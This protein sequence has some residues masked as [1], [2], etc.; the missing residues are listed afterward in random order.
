MEIL[1]LIQT[2]GGIAGGIGI[3]AFTKS[4]RLKERAEAEKKVQE[5]HRMMIDNYEERIKDLH[6]T[7]NLMNESE[8]HYI[9]RISAQNHA[10]DSKTEQI[11]NLTQ[12]VW[13]SEQEV[14]RV[15]ELLNAANQR[16]IE[17][18][19]ERDNYRNWHCRKGDCPHREP[20]NPSLLHQ[21]FHN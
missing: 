6:S 8:A 18:T 10:M 11:R 3:G 13:S 14:N 12:K 4:G 5:A 20:P 17:L 2:L 21:V 9:E 1:S 19:E 16:I 15:Q 7:I